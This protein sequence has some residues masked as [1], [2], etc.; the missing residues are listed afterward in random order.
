[1]LV[2]GRGSGGLGWMGG[3][4]LFG[5]SEVGSELGLEGCLNWQV[6]KRGLSLISISKRIGP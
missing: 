4:G 3:G 2:W 1:M 6:A 5:I